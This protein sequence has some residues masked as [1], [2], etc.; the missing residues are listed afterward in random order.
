MQASTT[1]TTPA[2]RGRPA[3]TGAPAATP[4]AA[5][6]N[7]RSMV[8][9]TAAP[10][11][12]DG[13]D[14]ETARIRWREGLGLSSGQIDDRM[15]DARARLV[16]VESTLA[17][18]GARKA[19][20]AARVEECRQAAEADPV[21]IESR[22]AD[23]AA[24]LCSLDDLAVA[25]A[26]MD[27]ARE[28]LPVVSAAH[29]TLSNEYRDMEKAHTDARRAIRNLEAAQAWQTLQAALAPAHAAISEWLETTG[30]AALFIEVPDAR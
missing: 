15:S 14:V 25:K 30:D 27:M 3:R 18:I 13:A 16:E 17:E 20:A 29:Y 8:Y 9:M 12:S 22:K 6:L 4:E 21:G 1:S 28:L 26:R 10:Y 7:V 5:A 19:K 24:G 11:Y 2:K 23:A